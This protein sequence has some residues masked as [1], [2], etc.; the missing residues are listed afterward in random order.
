MVTVVEARRRVRAVRGAPRG[1]PRPCSGRG[2]RGEAG[3]AG[4]ARDAGYA[5]EASA[6]FQVVDGRMIADAFFTSGR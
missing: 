5:S 1:S 4:D 3:C 6:S 2:E